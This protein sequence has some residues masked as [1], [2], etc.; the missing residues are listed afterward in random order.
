M[1]IN[2]LNNSNETS[3]QNYKKYVTPLLEKT[4]E[5]L[6]YSTDVSVS[7]VLVHDEEIRD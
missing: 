4:C 2:Y 5:M 3:W 6:D 1:E 7:I